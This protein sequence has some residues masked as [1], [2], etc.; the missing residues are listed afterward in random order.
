[1]TESNNSKKM[2]NLPNSGLCSPGWLL[3]KI[4]KREK[5]DKYLELARE[6]RKL[7]DIKTAVIPDVIG[8]IR[9]THQRMAIET[10]GT[11]NKRGIE[12]IQ[13]TVLLRSARILRRV[14][15]TLRRL[16]VTQTQFRNHSQTR[17]WKIVIIITIIIMII[18][19]GMG[20]CIKMCYARNERWQM[21]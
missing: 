4:E 3:S 19:I 20:F 12:I 11:G 7:W 5:K 2:Q 16:A 21:T 9:Y 8:M 17:V 10:G 13:I 6:L 18:I 1:M 14:P 15:N